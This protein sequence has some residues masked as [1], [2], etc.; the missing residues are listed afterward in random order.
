MKKFLIKTK[1]LVLL[2]ISF[3]GLSIFAIVA[4]LTVEKLK[5]NGSLYLKII[6]G[7]DL[8]AD[9]LPPPEYIIESYLTVFEMTNNDSDDK[10]N[11]YIQYFDKL[12]KEYYNRHEYW[13]KVLEPGDIRNL[14]LES[15]YNPADRFYSMVKGQLVPLLKEKRMDEAKNLVTSEIKPLYLQHR[16]AVDK[17]VEL[18]NKQ[19]GNNET[20]AHRAI[21]K[22]YIFLTILFFAI[23]IAIIIFSYVIIISISRPL[24]RGVE[25]AKSIAD[26]NLKQEFTFSNKDEIGQLAQSLA[27]MA[28]Q[29]KQVLKIVAESSNHLEKTSLQF[30]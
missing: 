25:F 5:I 1:L 8:V 12:Q 18:A 20:A 26:G 17:I 9:I 21:Q 13:T 16:N 3:L 15:A 6:E 27:E 29:L 2:S 10:L 24:A 4:Y 23:V 11:Q 30:N 28:N 7:K 14:M 22:Y 19:N